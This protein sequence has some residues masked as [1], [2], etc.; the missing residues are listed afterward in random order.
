MPTNDDSSSAD[1]SKGLRVLL[2][3][4]ISVPQGKFIHRVISYIDQERY[5]DDHSVI[6]KNVMT[7][8]GMETSQYRD[9]YPHEGKS[10]WVC[11]PSGT[12]SCS[13]NRPQLIV[14][15]TADIKRNRPF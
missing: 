13:L 10:C 7:R 9:T 6:N 5:V 11:W 14:D 15:N 1:T 3:D 12:I 8:C 2:G 4:P